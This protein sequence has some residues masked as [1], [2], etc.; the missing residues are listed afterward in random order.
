LSPNRL[1]RI[2]V[3]DALAHK[4][5][6]DEPKPMIDDDVVLDEITENNVSKIVN[7]NDSLDA[8][9]LDV[10]NLALDVRFFFFFFQNT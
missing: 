3:K 8:V 6:K 7:L 5:F 1:N 10:S 2:T 4:F 9:T